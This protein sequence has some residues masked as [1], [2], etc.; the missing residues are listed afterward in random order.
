MADTRRRQQ[1]QEMIEQRLAAVR[2]MVERS[3]QLLP[4]APEF[5]VSTEDVEVDGLPA[6]IHVYHSSDGGFHQ[7]VVQGYRPSATGITALVMAEGFQW[8]SA[9]VI[10]EMRP[11]ELY[12]YT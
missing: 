11:D 1:M 12:D 6:K 7:I 5:P 4:V 2:A 3:L 10:R 8:D 9:G